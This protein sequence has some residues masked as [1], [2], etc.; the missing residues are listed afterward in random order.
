MGF[1]TAIGLVAGARKFH[2]PRWYAFAAVCIAAGLGVPYLGLESIYTPIAI[3]F[4][5]VGG[6]AFITGLVMFTAFLIKYP[7]EKQP[8]EGAD[9]S[10]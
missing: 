6:V 10:G 8:Q 2:I 1:L 4:Q 5:I 7:V 9:E 3:E